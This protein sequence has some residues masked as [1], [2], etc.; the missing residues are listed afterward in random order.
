M[1]G[2]ES[3]CRLRVL[4]VEDEVI[5]AMSLEDMLVDLGYSV[6]GPATNLEDALDLAGNGDFE[7]ALLDVNLNGRQ[8]RPVVDLLR[9]RSIPYALITGYGPAALGASGEG[10]PIL[11]KPCSPAALEQLLREMTGR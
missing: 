10:A 11:T 5:V 8:S 6:V 9:G 2:R 1:T 3:D 7:A 4:V